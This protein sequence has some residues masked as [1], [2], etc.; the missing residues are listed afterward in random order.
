VTRTGTVS[1]IYWAVG[2]DGSKTQLIGDFDD[3]GW[4][5][6]RIPGPKV[7]GRATKLLPAIKYGVDQVASSADWT[8]GVIITDGIIEDEKESMDYCLNLGRDIAAKKHKPV[9]LVLI[10]IGEEVDED[11]LQRFD[12]MFEGTGIDYDL[13]SHGMVASMRDEGDILA[14]L[15]GE[16]A[17]EETVVASS[18]HV[19]DSKGRKLISWTD[20]V[21]G[22]FR[23]VLPKGESR[24]TLHVGDKEYTQDV[25]EALNTP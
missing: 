20:G 9:K 24:F 5:A 6:A 12:D 14:V 18:G 13:W 1:G 4:S 16:L 7:W 10:G 2:A 15:F 21:P 3:G 8:M 19:T 17:N 25:S 22:K 11:Q 23:F